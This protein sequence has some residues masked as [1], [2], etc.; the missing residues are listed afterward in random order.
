MQGG[1]WENLL[2]QTRSKLSPGN[3]CSHQGFVTSH[4]DPQW[5]KKPCI[6]LTDPDGQGSGQTF[7]RAEA[8]AG[9]AGWQPGSGPS[10]QVSLGSSPHGSWARGSRAKKRLPA[11]QWRARRKNSIPALPADLLPSEELVN[12]NKNI[13]ISISFKDFYKE[14]AEESGKGNGTPLQYSSLENPMD[15]GAW[16]AAV[17]GVARSQT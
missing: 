5:S 2:T 6:V 15:R 11:W 12:L 16:W 17:Y 3:S 14:N 8:P 13:N 1:L 10:T 9:G 4:P 7:K